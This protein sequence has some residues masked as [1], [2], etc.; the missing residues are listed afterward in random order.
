VYPAL[1]FYEQTP[2]LTQYTYTLYEVVL[3]ISGNDIN[4][5]NLFQVGFGTMINIIGAL[6]MAYIFGNITYLI[7]K[8]SANRI[9]YEEKKE[10]LKERMRENTFPKT[11]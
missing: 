11:L 3:F 10:N 2:Y 6:M 4:P 1:H 9:E 7:S 8:L 5:V